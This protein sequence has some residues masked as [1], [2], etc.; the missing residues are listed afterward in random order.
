MLRFANKD[1]FI[2]AVISRA[3]LEALH[4]RRVEAVSGHLS[5]RADSW[6]AVLGCGVAYYYAHFLKATAPVTPAPPAKLYTDGDC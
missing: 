1:E 4:A 5:L 2:R 3:D 6:H